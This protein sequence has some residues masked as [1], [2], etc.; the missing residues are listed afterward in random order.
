MN[1]VFPV[2]EQCVLGRVAIKRFRDF[3]GAVASVA[4]ALVGGL[5]LLV[6][7]GQVN[8][9]QAPE[10]PESNQVDWQADGSIDAKVFATEAIAGVDANSWLQFAQ[11]R[12]IGQTFR[13][14]QPRL[15]MVQFGLD[16]IDGGY[17]GLTCRLSEAQQPNVTVR[18]RRDGPDGELVAQQVYR[19]GDIPADLPLQVDVPSDPAM[20]WYIEAEVDRQD[21]PDP[22]AMIVN[23]TA[24]DRYVDGQLYLDG[25]PA[26]G[27][28]H[29]RI[30]G[31]NH[32]AGVWPGAFVLWAA[33]AEA[34]VWI[35]PDDVIGLMLADNPEKPIE[36]AGARDEWVCVQITATPAPGQRIDEA[37]LVL[38]ELTGPDGHAIGQDDVRI[39]WL[40]YSHE[41]HHNGSRDSGRWYPD[42]LAP[43]SV[44]RLVGMPEN[45]RANV[46]FWVEIRVPSGAAA[47][48]YHGQVKVRVNGG[49]DGEG[50]GGAVDLERS[51]RLA[52]RDY[53]M[54]SSTST[55]T[56]L[57][58]IRGGSV[59]RHRAI[60][61]DLAQYR[62]ANGASLSRYT[63]S[64]LRKAD[65]SEAAYD[66]VL[67]AEMQQSLIATGEVLEQHGLHS[68]RINPWADTYRL[69]QT[70]SPE[71][72]EGI[73]RFWKTYYPIL[74]ERGWVDSAYTRMVDEIDGDEMNTS[75]VSSIAALFREH[76]P[77]VKIMVTAM[78]TPDV[79]QL[80]RAIGIVDIWA[81]SSRYC[82]KAMGF[83]Q[84]RLAAGEQVWP[85][86]HDYLFHPSDVAGG[87][88]FF[89]MLHKYGFQ[90]TTLWN[91]A[92]R[93]EFEHTWFGIIRRDAV[94]PGDGTLYYPGATDARFMDMWRSVRLARIRD[95]L[96]DRECLLLLDGL[97]AQA[98]EKGVLTPEL[99]E[100]VA[101]AQSWAGRLTHGMGNFTNDLSAVGR[102]RNAIDGAIVA[103]QMV[104]AG[105]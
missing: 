57:F 80:S 66:I 104:L 96:E 13:C 7:A 39:H 38:D 98:N 76:A 69:F 53:T 1:Q 68:L 73:I 44:A 75:N 19:P 24:D 63:H 54:P 77:G 83:Y 51:I 18:L 101:D 40:R 41:I 17:R 65:F 3:V 31:E 26:E 90:G 4:V 97:V 62:I 29:L 30:T 37:S 20:V 61:E 22:T 34:R 6:L 79:E 45:Q 56:G 64:I 46:T 28:L 82:A 55:H 32:L 43:T 5:C 89:W 70:G 93:G 48:D 87:R 50:A 33:P 2:G 35:N 99:A 25:E 102:A 81:P 49:S 67:G 105:K 60:T 12:R 27:D 47:G 71:A 72:R 78:G 16:G 15:V 95:G 58:K 86:I 91:V 8:A 103:L 59:V 42:P 10:T 14:Q 52:V 23:A 100:Q 11:H 88:L 36:L 92:P 21:Y 94:W 84:Q 9:M 74:K 85:Y